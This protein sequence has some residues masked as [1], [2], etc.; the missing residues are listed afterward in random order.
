MR[1]GG[2]TIGE[3]DSAAGWGEE[4]SAARGASETGRG[5]DRR[6]VAEG[7]GGTK[8]V[9]E[10]GKDRAERTNG[11]RKREVG[12]GVRGVV[13]FRVGITLDFRGDVATSAALSL[14]LF[15]LLLRL[16]RPDFSRR[17]SFVSCVLPVPVRRTHP[18]HP[19]WIPRKSS[20][21][22]DYPAKIDP[23]ARP[24]LS[25][26][27]CAVRRPRTR[28][29]TQHCNTGTLV[30]REKAFLHYITG[31]NISGLP[32]KTAAPARRN[33]KLREPG[34]GLLALPPRRGLNDW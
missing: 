23:F 8:R 12:K 15:L 1:S 18:V 21:H 29:A 26:T 14:Q 25:R 16:C 27:P 34:I 9:G 31:P 19:P 11:A 20:S 6:R 13:Q 24:S 2:E 33:K 10:R 32:R 3:G 28:N 17:R 22:P 5:K 4:G 30:F 7:R